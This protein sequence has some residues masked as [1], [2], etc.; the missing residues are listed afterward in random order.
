MH[1]FIN[2][3]QNK[4]LPQQQKEKIITKQNISIQNLKIN[5]K[6]KIKDIVYNVSLQLEDFLTL[7]FI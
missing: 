5:Y 1:N 6:Q 4:A 2:V 3:E 7:F